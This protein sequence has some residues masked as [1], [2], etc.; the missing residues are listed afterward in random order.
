VKRRGKGGGWAEA[1]KNVGLEKE[2]GLG[3]TGQ[4]P[5]TSELGKLIIALFREPGCKR[6]GGICPIPSIEEGKEKGKR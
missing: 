2:E 1:V 4:L 3:R 5:R 6:Q